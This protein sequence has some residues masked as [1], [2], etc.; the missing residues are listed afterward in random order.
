M[1]AARFHSLYWTADGVFTWGLN[2]GQLGHIKVRYRDL[3][4]QDFHHQG[5]RTVIQPKLVASLSNR[6]GGVSRWLNSLSWKFL[7]PE[8]KDSVLQ[9]CD[10]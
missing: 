8:S 2:A 3:H 10:K 6:E 9:G 7:L 5:E 1:A 4:H